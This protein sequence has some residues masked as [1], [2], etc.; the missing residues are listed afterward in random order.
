[1]NLDEKWTLLTL[2]VLNSAH[3]CCMLR[4]WLHSFPSA[5]RTFTRPYSLPPKHHPKAINYRQFKLAMSDP[6]QAAAADGANLH[7]DPVTGE[8]VSKSCV[9]LSSSA[10]PRK[11][12]LTTGV[13]TFDVSAP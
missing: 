13:F 9:Q 1:M 7:K 11:G 8:M 10:R 4:T 12:G 3:S 2:L 5:R 6:A